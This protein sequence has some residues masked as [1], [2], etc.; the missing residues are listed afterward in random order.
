MAVPH[1]PTQPAASVAAVGPGFARVTW[2]KPEQGRGPMSYEIVMKQ[3]MTVNDQPARATRLDGYGLEAGADYT[4]EI[5]SVTADGKSEPV[6]TNAVTP[7]KAPVSWV[8]LA[9]SWLLGAVV[10]V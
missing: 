6:T 2:K 9:S 5:R 7:E 10:I 4:F 1:P 3:T 8:W